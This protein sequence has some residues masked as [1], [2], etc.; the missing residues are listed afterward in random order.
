MGHIPLQVGVT[1][2]Y[3]KNG[4]GKTRLLRA[5]RSAL[6]GLAVDGALGLLHV[7]VPSVHDFFA[8]PWRDGFENGMRTH[9]VDARGRGLAQITN[10]RDSSFSNEDYGAL[11]EAVES[12]AVFAADMENE[13]FTPTSVGEMVAAHFRQLAFGPQVLLD[14]ETLSAITQEVSESGFFALL[15]DGAQNQPGWRVFAAGH[16]GLPQFTQLVENDHK[17]HTGVRQ[18]VTKSPTIDD[19]WKRE[20]ADLARLSTGYP[21]DSVLPFGIDIVA[22]LRPGQ[23]G[24]PA[25]AKEPWPEPWPTWATIPAL[26]VGRIDNIPIRLVADLADPEEADLATRDLLLKTSNRQVVNV[27]TNDEV[28]LTTQ[29]SLTVAQLNETSTE[30]ITSLLR[31]AP[32][33]RLNIGTPT[34]WFAGHPPHWQMKDQGGSNWFGLNEASAAQR[35]W[36]ALAIAAASELADPDGRPVVL[37]CDEPEAGL[38]GSIEE[39]LPAALSQ[40]AVQLGAAVVAATHSAH[41]LDER[42]VDPMHVTRMREF[43]V[44]RAMP[45]AVGDALDRALAA[46]E[47]GISASSLLQMVRCFVAVEGIHDKLVLQHFIGDDLREMRAA[48]MPIGGGATAPSL[49]EAALLFDFTDAQIVVVLDGVAA[50]AVTPCWKAAIAHA[51]EGN[52]KKA[53]RELL[54][55]EK[56]PG[57]EALWL[58]DLLE[59]AINTG[60]WNRIVP[61]PLAKPDIICYLPPDAFVQGK[62]W[63]ELLTEWQAF[64]SPTRPKDLKGWLAE[65]YNV[66]VSGRMIK[67]ALANA[68]AQ[69]EILALAHTIRSAIDQ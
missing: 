40:M 52:I 25:D 43:T 8:D 26:E 15:A 64:H 66:T 7:R 54:A 17:V 37:L 67:G 20:F 58:R 39:R 9:L 16:P 30:L 57:W 48:V 38:H 24:I 63:P 60:R 2:L 44:T 56:I 45:S 51:D 62:S 1:A 28:E 22:G 50:K 33:L 6:A 42:S 29:L 55:L 53:R 19:A 32:E 61:A 10:W 3:G 36:A 69:D 68:V 59:R 23:G 14:A 34:E 18:L 47:L 12:I 27:A 49:A 11:D 4:V 65:Q 46:E 13:E 21:W 35:R 5:L 31:P 41:M